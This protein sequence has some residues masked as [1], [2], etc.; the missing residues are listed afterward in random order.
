MK[1]IQTKMMLFFTLLVAV[2]LIAAQIITY[3][4]VSDQREIKIEDDAHWYVREVLAEIDK[5]FTSK[6]MELKRYLQADVLANAMKVD[7]TDEEKKKL[8]ADFQTYADLDSNVLAVFLGKSNKDLV[9]SAVNG[10]RLAYDP[11][12][13]DWYKQAN[14]R[15]NRIVWSAPYEDKVT[16]E[17]VITGSKAVI[18]SQTNAVI[19]VI[20]MDI[21][22]TTITQFIEDLEIDFGGRVFVVDGQN[23]ALE[24][25]NK[26]GQD[27]SSEYIIQEAGKKADGVFTHQM[28]GEE[29]KVYHSILGKLGWNVGIIFPVEK[30][31]EELTNMRNTTLIV[32]CVAVLLTLVVV[33]I[34]AR[35]IARP[36]QRLNEE[37][38][39]VAEGDLTVRI[40]SDMKDEVGQLTTN[41]SHMVE[42]MHGMVQMI[43]QS[44][45]NVESGSNGVHHLAAETIASSKEIASAMDSVARNATDQANEIENITEKIERISQ[46]ISDVNV[47]I[48]SMGHLSNESDTVSQAGVSK[49]ASLRN[50][51]EVSNTQLH[52]AEAVMGQL[53]ERVRLISDVISTIRSISDQTNLLA[54]NASIEAAR[55]GEHGKG[56]AVV[57]QEVRKLAEQSKQATEHV[58]QTIKGIQEETQ[59]AV[60][61]MTQT[62][63]LADEQKKSLT[64]TEDVFLIIT[65]IS[66]Q[67]RYSITDISKAMTNI[68]EE[69][70]AFGE[71]LQEF[72][73]GS[74]ET[75]A[76]SEEVNASTDEQL[77][78]LQQVEATSEQLIEQTERLKELVKRFNI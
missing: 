53:V 9:V 46:S 52:N 28:D 62:R 51:S 13:R 30:M 74:Q 34:I 38:K 68:G 23:R 18:D 14:E 50:A 27:V 20:G 77:T 61:A 16:K 65:S 66:E 37:V 73:A 49:I 19:G 2:A 39:K 56:F 41:F 15:P 1:K 48:G 11:T 76:A 57:A 12:E 43:E 25:P 26:N 21:S 72:A 35:T 71:V 75:A 29:V 22:L 55:A 67:V 70:A 6:E 58:G 63:E 44:V 60:E 59:K 45:T 7:A 36:I 31:E 24:Y 5:I 47:S 17:M 42:E 54:L 32:L 8:E 10:E 40:Q 33:Y 64:E 4:Q 78:H 3:V 69:Q